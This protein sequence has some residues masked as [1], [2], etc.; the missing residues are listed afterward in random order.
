MNILFV[1]NLYPPITIG[2]YEQVCFD[3]AQGL[4]ARGQSVH[5]LTSSYR[6]HDLRHHESGVYRRLKLL[7]NW[8]LPPSGPTPWL[9][10]SRTE[11]EWHNVRSL[12][13]AMSRLR[14]DVVMFWNSANL[15]RDLL[16]T[17]EHK[18]PTI[19]YLLDP[20][21]SAVLVR[22]TQW[23]AAPLHT[24][25][26]RN[27]YQQALRVA[28][29]P[30]GPIE[31]R[32]L[33]FVSKALQSQYSHMG[34][35]VSRGEV[36]YNGVDPNLF[37][38]QAQHIAHRAAGEPYRILFS[39]R[40]TPEKGIITLLAAL[41]KLRAQPGLEQSRLSLLG[42]PQS[43]AYGV[44]LQDRITQLGLENAI[45]FLQ[46]VPR[47]KVSTI[48]A[49]H[50]LLAFPSEWEEPFALTLLEGMAVGIPVVTTLT[51]GSA[52]IVRDYEN[53]IAFQ[54]ANPDDLAQKLAWTL[55][56]PTEAAQ[57]GQ[58]ASQQI[59]EHHTITTQVTSIEAY[60]Q[61]LIRNS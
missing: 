58:A 42:V 51:G 53:A 20:W 50:D 3:I 4:K 34:L 24:R 41:N 54:A 29:I 45:D 25:I 57:I 5:V 1:S 48:Y 22:Q 37:S 28:G 61:N 32:H 46:P 30:R 39:G 9:A 59:R 52:E 27:I 55:T 15:G 56:H 19:Y 60:L 38:F 40:I 2:G 49:E 47:S 10:R 13:R 12:R 11:A 14:P 6:A 8:G 21:L 23:A 7:T 43:A 33:L 26:P 18:V 35:D 44:E 31:A 36:V 16:S 17:A